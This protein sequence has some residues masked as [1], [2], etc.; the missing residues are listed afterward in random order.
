MAAAAAAISGVGS[1]SLASANVAA[2]HA[3]AEGLAAAVWAT[4]GAASVF[5]AICAISKARLQALPVC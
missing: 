4:L 5:V 2:A 1:A 3:A